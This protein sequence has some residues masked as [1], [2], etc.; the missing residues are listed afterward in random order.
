MKIAIAGYGLEGE[1]NY[2]YFSQ[3]QTNELTVVDQ[4]QPGRAVPDD[5]LT[6]IGEDAFSNLDG[7]DMVV[8]TAGLAPSK[9][10]TDGIVWSATNEFFEKCPALIIGVTGSKGKGT[11]ASLIA[12]IVRAAGKK[13]WLVGNIGVPALDV[14]AEI[15]PGDIVVYEL[16]SFQLWDMQRSPHIAVILYIEQEHLDVHSDMNDYVSAK[17]RIT[18]FQTSNDILVFNQRNQFCQ[19]IAARS[20]A[21]GIGYQDDQTAHVALGS[22]YYGEQLLCSAGALQLIGQHNLDNACAAIDAIWSITS[23]PTAIEAGIRRFTGLPHRLKFVR[24]VTGVKYYDDS[25]ATTPTS[26]IA[27]LKSFAVPKVIILGGSSKGADFDL[28]GDE[29]AR[30]DVKA[31]LIGDEAVT[32][33]ASCQKAGFD[34]FE[35]LRDVTMAQIV[36]RAATLAD[37]GTVVLLSPASASFG[38][39]KNYV[40]RG[41]QYIAA[42][43]AL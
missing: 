1:S 10:K 38:M 19:A 28:L 17:E 30:N 20:L 11:T 26:A 9:I 39:F 32:I 23:D 43:Q 15:T 41:D 31:I 33:A 2:R 37:P 21:T 42:V 5:V 27:A 7:F 40:D 24:E 29:L 14:L 18:A 12:S 4:H 13:V 36:E 8:R 6:I 25:I 16:S 22:F 35:I 3:N 34:D